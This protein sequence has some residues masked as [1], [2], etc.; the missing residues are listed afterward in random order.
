MPPDT[1]FAT[2]AQLTELMDEPSTYEE[3]RDCLRDLEKVNRTV[4]SYRPTLRW[5]KQFTGRAAAPLHIVD[6]GS[7]GGDT[8]RHIDRW[9]Q[10]QNLPVRL[11]GIDLNSHAARAAR[12]FSGPA[13]RIEWISSDAF[14]WRPPQPV[15]LVISS[16]FTHHLSD[17]EIVRFLEWMEQTAA[18]GWF[19]NDLSRG[20]IS[21]YGFKLLA[22]VM[23][24][25]RFVQHDGPVSILRSFTAE[26]WQGYLRAAGLASLPIQ[27]QPVR[28]GRLCVSRVK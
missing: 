23:R 7:G 24:W 28:P 5:L 4:L 1:F 2:R 11:T 12:E 15:D 26:D 25:H 18:R 20:R 8:L 16:L 22:R 14:S 6:V 27:I 10:Q 17:G 13:S 21:Y 19:I 9:A 3:F